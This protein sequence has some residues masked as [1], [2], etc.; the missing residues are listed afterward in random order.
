MKKVIRLT[1]YDLTRIVKRV[2][3]EESEVI[4]IKTWNTKEDRDNNLPRKYNMD[5]TNHKLINNTVYFDGQIVGTETK[6]TGGG[7]VGSP[8]EFSIRCGD[9]SGLIE[10]EQAYITGHNLN[11]Q[12]IT[13]AARK[14]LTKKC[15]S[16]VSKDTKV[17]GNYA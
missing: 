13:D 8:N 3:K 5:T 2:L 10:L 9:M 4:K 17:N 14:L 15:D 11:S 16:Y 6:T 12:Y 7:T 1:E